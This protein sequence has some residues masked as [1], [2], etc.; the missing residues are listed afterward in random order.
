MD[1]EE[2]NQTPDAEPSIKKTKV[3][4]DQVKKNG[5]PALTSSGINGNEQHSGIR[6][7]NGPEE[8]AKPVVVSA[9]KG[10]SSTKSPIQEQTIQV[11][12]KST[13]LVLRIDKQNPSFSTCQNKS[14]TSLSN[15]N[16]KEF[17][18]VSEKK[19]LKD[20]DIKPD[21][22]I[23]K[24]DVKPSEIKVECNKTDFKSIPE[25]IPISE[26]K[27]DT[28][29]MDVDETKPMP[30]FINTPNQS[31][32][33]KHRILSIASIIKPN[34]P[35]PQAESKENKNVDSAKSSTLLPSQSPPRNIISELTEAREARCQSNLKNELEKSVR[36]GGPQ[37][38]GLANGSQKAL[39]PLQEKPKQ[40]KMTSGSQILSVINNLTKK[41]LNLEA[42]L[43]K[44][45]K[46]NGSISPALPSIVKKPET[47]ASSEVTQ[48]PKTSSSPATIPTSSSKYVPQTPATTTSHHIPS[49]TTI[50]VKQIFSSS[51][52]PSA[53]PPTNGTPVVVMPNSLKSVS[54]KSLLSN[55]TIL[56]PT[57]K[58]KQTLNDLRQFRKMPLDSTQTKTSSP[59]TQMSLLN[60]QKS[61][62]SSLL[63]NLSTHTSTGSH[64]LP[65]NISAAGGLAAMKPINLSR[66]PPSMSL[67]DHQKALQLLKSSVSKNSTSFPTLSNGKST[68]TLTT[69]TSPQQ[70]QLPSSRL[71]LKVQQAPPLSS[72][73]AAFQSTIYTQLAAE[74][75]WKHQQS[76]A[77]AVLHAN[78]QLAS[79]GKA[80]GGLT[81]TPNQG[82]RQI[83]NP[84]LFAK[85]QQEIMMAMA[86]AVIN[87][88]GDPRPNGERQ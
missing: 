61:L 20:L 75:I 22:K 5:A 24:P 1:T 74:T 3:I 4:D 58:S 23:P 62:T 81:K 70:A 57:E 66:P 78:M 39:S 54:P 51:S 84:S 32:P 73:Q 11:T 44:D 25:S 80:F 47:S 68:S 16:K 17:E 43:N 19:E 41:Q 8:I 76:A 2:S 26:E 69:T 77:A 29:K 37:S 31:P 64:K 56:S 6:S 49:G 48:G 50:T 45:A 52:S 10:P 38:P 15:D 7:Y 53:T 21:E 82:I 36:N 72:F 46:S 18:K 65:G 30:K 14:P 88:G 55:V 60:K 83:P 87:G 9:E 27:K 85:Q 67:S 28:E 86:A 71:Q 12:S 79:N 63:S 13:C 35:Q 42:S 33:E 59:S 40:N 34:N